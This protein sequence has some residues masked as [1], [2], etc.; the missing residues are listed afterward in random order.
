MK[1]AAAT[2]LAANLA[3]K[4]FVNAGTRAGVNRGVWGSSHSYDNP[5]KLSACTKE[6][7][8]MGTK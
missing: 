6:V 5:L 1:M 3:I 7:F 2:R 8:W 4:T